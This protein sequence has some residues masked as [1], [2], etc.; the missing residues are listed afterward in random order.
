ME[1]EKLIKKCLKERLVRAKKWARENKVKFDNNIIEI[2]TTKEIYDG[3]NYKNQITTV[4]FRVNRIVEEMV[5]HVSNEFKD[6]TWI[7]EL[8]EVLMTGCSF[9]IQPKVHYDY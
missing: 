2:N 9:S 5:Q 8:E 4:G 6:I 3:V 1:R 7:K